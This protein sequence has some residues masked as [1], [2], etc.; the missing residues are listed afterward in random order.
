MAELL[1]N[2]DFETWTEGLPNSWEKLGTQTVAKETTDVHAGTGALKLTTTGP[3]TGVKQKISGIAKSQRCRIEFWQHVDATAAEP[4]NLWNAGIEIQISGGTYGGLFL[5]FTN[6]QWEAETEANEKDIQLFAKPTAG[7]YVKVA[8]EFDFPAEAG[9][10]YLSIKR[11][12]GTSFSSWFDAVSLQSIA[13]PSTSTSVDW[14]EYEKSVPDSKFA[15]DIFIATYGTPDYIGF[16]REWGGDILTSSDIATLD[17]R[18]IVPMISWEPKE[19]AP[20]PAAIAEGKHDAYIDEQAAKI[21]AYGKRV[22]I[23]P[24]W[25]MNIDLFGFGGPMDPDDYVEA[26]QRIVTRFN[27]AG[28]TN[29]EWFWCPMIDFDRGEN[30]FEGTH[31]FFPYYPGEEY[32]DYVGADGYSNTYWDAEKEKAGWATLKDIFYYTYMCISA[33][34]TK[35]F[36]IG[37]TGV[38]EE[39]GSKSTWIT[40][41]YLTTIPQTFP[42]IDAVMYFNRHNVGEV[43]WDIASSESAKNAF[44]EAAANSIYLNMKPLPLSAAEGKAE[45]SLALKVEGGKEATPLPL[46]AAAGKGST[47]LALEIEG[48]VLPDVE[49][50]IFDTLALNDGTHFVIESEL[51]FTAAVKKPQFIGNADTDG[52]VLLEEAHYGNAT[53]EFTLRALGGATHEAGRNRMDELVQK[54]LEADRTQGGLPLAW[55][56]TQ[57]SPSVWEDPYTWY[58]L[59]GEIDGIPITY[60]GDDAGWFFKEPVAKV[61]LTCRPF[62]YRKE[63]VVKSATESSAAPQQ[64]VY[65][66]VGG[67]V[68]AEGRLVVTDKATVKRRYMEWGREL[69]DSD[70]GNPSVLFKGDDLVITG[71]AAKEKKAR[72]GTWSTNAI[73]GS[74][75]TTTGEVIFSTPTLAHVGTYRV[76]LRAIEEL[77]LGSRPELMWRASYRVG[78][79]PWGF[80]NA[81]AWQGPLPSYR[82]WC[83]LDLG[84]VVLEKLSKGTQR[85]E[86]RVEVK[87]SQS[88]IFGGTTDYYADTL[89]LVPTKSYGRARGA[90][91]LDNPDVLAEYD[92]FMGSGALTGSILNRGGTWAGAGDATDFSFYEGKVERSALSDEAAGIH[93][94]RICTANGTTAQTDQVMSSYLSFGTTPGSELKQGVICR[95]DGTVENFLTAYIAKQNILVVAK[96]VAG[97]FTILGEMEVTKMSFLVPWKITLVVLASGKWYVAFGMATTVEAGEIKMTGFDSA[98]SAGGALDNGRVGILDH[99]TSASACTRWHSLTQGWIPNVPSVIETS[100][101]LEV[102]ADAIEREDV[103]G[104]FWGNVP[105]YRGSFFYLD[106]EGANG[107]YNRLVVRA[108]RGDIVAEPDENITD[109]QTVEVLARER[110]LYPLK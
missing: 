72:A 45:T 25:E 53:F 42:H 11:I 26:W 101:S 68:P 8:Y 21:A 91:R 64:E 47:S 105:E 59:I 102:R 48:Q 109:K 17:A 41:G 104:T 74:A 49:Q 20:T 106:P 37:E 28:A 3:L 10:L 98:L 34:T 23:R 103:G 57:S 56:P 22:I 86:I 18:L 63:K 76:K 16:F 71:Y 108:R 55:I 27:S 66:K 81:G 32:V 58:V 60:Q 43:E 87:Y 38:E 15:L 110:V 79:G 85:C 44:I 24:Y 46:G 93:K 5:N 94:G 82:T 97:V 61:K 89:T 54:L 12:A 52:E 33:L 75:A 35:P 62:G 30:S 107:Q 70:T 36:I 40:T 83:E 2:G 19:A 7:R 99:Y 67:H 14:G 90:I 65:A 80:P 92:D 51:A 100:Q 78:D 9:A 96:R 69:V 29:A 1:A 39:G 73:F 84:E 95:G 31:D 50:L 77:S 13:T 6:G 4:A 88:D